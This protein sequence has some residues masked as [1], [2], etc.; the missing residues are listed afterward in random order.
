M[1]HAGCIGRTDDTIPCRTVEL[2]I[3]PP[4]KEEK[5]NKGLIDSGRWYHPSSN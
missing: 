5:K 1:H 2:L 3:D 4:E